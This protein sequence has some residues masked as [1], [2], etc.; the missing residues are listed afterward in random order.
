VTDVDRL[1]AEYIEEHREGG[2][3][4]PTTFLS[5]AV[6][7]D[8]RELA[9]LIDGYLRRAPRQRFDAAGFRGSPS[10]RVVDELERALGGQAGLWPALL[11]ELRHRAGL[12]CA[13]LVARLAGT[14]GLAGREPKVATYYHQ[15]EQ[16]ILP[17]RGVSN[18]VLAALGDIVG[19]SLKSLREAGDA[20]TPFDGAPTPAPTFARLAHAD[21]ASG[22][23]SP[24]EAPP[25]EEWD[26][27]DILFRGG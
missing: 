6:A 5:R 16:G 15:M 26:E 20:L 22:M 12:K 2:V 25:D 7:S 3:A 9:A 4:D 8:R 13:E 21:P 18:R 10:E 1:L 17:A 24:E 19:E 23:A 11:P 27:I 14:L